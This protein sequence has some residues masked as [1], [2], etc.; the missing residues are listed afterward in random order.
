M[1]GLALALVL[2]LHLVSGSL[3]PLRRVFGAGWVGVD[4]FF[5][6]SG[7]LITRILRSSLES[8]SFFRNFYARRALRIWPLYLLIL[9]FAFGGT[10]LLPTGMQIGPALLPFYLTFTQNLLSSIGFGPW[11]LAVT[12]SL[13]IEEQF[14]LVYPLSVRFLSQ[15]GLVRLLLVLLVAPPLARLVALG[16]GIS[17]NTVYISTW[18]RLDTLA[19]GA[20]A[21]LLVESPLRARAEQLSVPVSI[22]T[23]AVAAVSCCVCFGG[24]VLILEHSP[25]AGLRAVVYAF[26]FSIIAVGF[27]SLIVLAVSDRAPV[28]RWVLRNRSLRTLG[29]VSFGVYLIHGITIA[30]AQTIW[31]AWLHDAGLSG[32]AL[33]ACVVIAALGSALILAGISWRFIEAPALRLRRLFPARD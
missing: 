11:A 31:R 15:G 9:A 20:L 23:L 24:D 22:G 12:W 5:V 10:R 19:A 32:K 7:F 21:A 29:K 1:R 28:L 25:I 27:A 30:I 13:A 2:V 6:L 26:T 17:P 18:Y 14:Y 4:L 16:H 8:R 33:S 3:G